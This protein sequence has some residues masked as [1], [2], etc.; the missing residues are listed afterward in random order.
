M[1]IKKNQQKKTGYVWVNK[2]SNYISSNKFIVQLYYPIKS[3]KKIQI[4]CNKCFI[5]KLNLSF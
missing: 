1:H 4:A 2:V 3:N 5:Y